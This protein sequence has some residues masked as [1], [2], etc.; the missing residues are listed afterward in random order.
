MLTRNVLDE[1]YSTIYR[2][3]ARQQNYFDKPEQIDFT[4][5]H[6]AQ[7]CYISQFV[8]FQKVKSVLDIGSGYGFLLREIRKKH[9]GIR[10]I[11]MDP[12]IANLKYLKN[13]NIEIIEGLFEDCHKNLLREKPD[14][15]IASHVVEHMT[16][17]KIFFEISAKLLS[18]NGKIFFEVP[19][20]NFNNNTF[21]NRAYD[22]PHLLFFTIPFLI[23]LFSDLRLNIINITTAGPLL[24]SAWDFMRA[25]QNKTRDKKFLQGIKFYN[26]IKR[27][28]PRRVKFG[29]RGF[30][31]NN[32]ICYDHYQYGGEDRSAIRGII[33]RI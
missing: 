27:F 3:A 29:L 4:A 28:I 25:R 22:T 20:N 15:I 23:N 1:F 32:V 16:D 2:D 31:G 12:D 13:Y 33:S 8:D 9:P 26:M 24:D 11:A 19:N 17:P 6:N 21:M 7:Y 18:E 30:L 10:L 5:L 14:L